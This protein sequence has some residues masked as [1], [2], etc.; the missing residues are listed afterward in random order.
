MDFITGLPWS[1]GNDAIWVVVDWLTKMRHLLP[2]LTTIDAPSLAD[3]FLDNIWKHDGLPLTII[4]D[5]GP[6]FAAE[7]WGTICRRLKIDRRLSTAF[8]PETDGQTERVNGIMEQYLRS[9]VNYQQDDWYQWLRMAEFMGNY[10]ASETTISSPFIAN[11]GY[12]PSMDFLDE[13]TLP[14]DDQEARSFVI[15]MTELHAH[16][17]TEMGCAQ[18]RQQD[19]ADRRRVPAPFFQVGYKVWLNAKNIRTRRPSRKLDN[20]HH[21]AY[22]VKAK[23]GTEAY[24]LDLPNTMKIHNV[25]HVS[26]LDLAANYPL[27]GQIIPPPPP[28]E[29]EGDE[30]RQVQEVLDSKFVR[31]L[32]RYLVKWEGYDETTWELAESINELT[33]VDDFHERYLLK[34]GPLRENPE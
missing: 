24:R 4:S 26:L 16:L 8:L 20:K 14:T 15:T 18:E 29:V 28:V 12:D 21:G 34:R 10:H 13:Q 32:L 25:F 22:E 3:L 11:Y 7:F 23:I 1:N 5:R 9:Y 27:E 19:N 31:N 33:A 2:C 6:Q 30:W 17:R